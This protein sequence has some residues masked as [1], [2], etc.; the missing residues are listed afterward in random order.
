MS[1]LVSVR[2]CLSI[3]SIFTFNGLHRVLMPDDEIGAMFEH[4]L[5]QIFHSFDE[6]FGS[7]LRRPFETKMIRGAKVLRIEAVQ[8][9]NVVTV[10]GK[11]NG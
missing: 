6:E 8:R 11:D 2:V 1:P 7:E 10:P 3:I 5:S 9:K 4:R